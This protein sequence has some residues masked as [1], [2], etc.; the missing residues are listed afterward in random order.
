MLASGNQVEQYHCVFTVCVM[1]LIVSVVGLHS[2]SA[3]THDKI[4]AYII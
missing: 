3:L 4:K 2:V 1:S